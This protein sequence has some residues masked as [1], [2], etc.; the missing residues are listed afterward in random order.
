[1]PTPP[2]HRSWDDYYIPGT[3]TLRNRFVV[4]G[5]PSQTPYGVAD[6]IK[7][8]QLT[9]WASH[10][11]LVQLHGQ[12]ILGNFDRAQME[13]IHA[14][15]FQDV[16]NWAGQPRTAPDGPM[17]K[18][19]HLYYP[20]DK[21]MTERLDHLYGMLRDDDHLRGLDLK[22]FPK[23]LG[24]YWANI[25]T[26]HEFREG[27]TRSQFVFFSGLCDQAGYSLDTA[28]FKPGN[29]LRDQF[30]AARFKAQ[31]TGRSSDLAK[32]LAK[33][34]QPKTEVE[35]SLARMSDWSPYSAPERELPPKAGWFSSM[36]HQHGRRSVADALAE[37]QHQQ[38]RPSLQRV[39]GSHP[40]QQTAATAGWSTP[41]LRPA[42]ENDRPKGGAPEC[43]ALR[44]S[45]EDAKA[46]VRHDTRRRRMNQ[47]DQAARPLDLGPWS[48]SADAVRDELDEASLMHDVT[49]EA[50]KLI[51]QLPDH[52]IHAAIQS[53]VTDYHWEAFD[54][55]RRSAISRLVDEL[56]PGQA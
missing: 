52:V 4:P 13:A 16:Y 29:P 47:L 7:A 53:S 12:P 22:G 37:Q 10:F 54:D 30:V 43:T 18:A 35:P 56:E 6:P 19:G 46:Q 14:H 34:I 51:Q 42:Q 49:E 36:R 11:R 1:M 48:L 3:Q 28:M 20:G 44:T 31:D 24:A 38:T 55:L 41:E 8:E 2:K 9:E 50:A 5:E 27:N 26:A 15:L 17:S 45:S 40:D 32:V 25:N 21:S 33:G 23:A 39:L